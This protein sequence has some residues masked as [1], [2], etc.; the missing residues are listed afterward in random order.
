[1]LEIDVGVYRKAF[2]DAGAFIAL[3]VLIQMLELL[4]AM[5]LWRA[6]FVLW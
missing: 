2:F 5:G 4:R 1:V 6:G 3:F